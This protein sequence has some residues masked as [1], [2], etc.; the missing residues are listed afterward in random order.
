[1]KN[2]MKIPIAVSALLLTISS[3]S[4]GQAVPAGAPNTPISSIGSAPSAL[5]LD[6]TLHYALSAS[7]I[8]QYGYFGA[9]EVTH[10]TALSAD[11]AYTAKSMVYPFNVLFAGGVILQNQAGQGTTSFWNIEAS[12]GLV[13]RSWVFNV[14]DSFS[15]LPQSPT[16]G[17]SGI[18]G[19]GDLGSIPVQGPTEGP[20]GGIFSDAGNR[21][22][23]SVSGSAERQITRDTSISGS[24]SWLI[25]QFLGDSA[26]SG[27]NNSSVTGSVAVN[28]RLDARTSA[29][30]AAVYSTFTYSGVQSGFA[31]PDIETKGINLSFQRVLTRRLSVSVSA[32]PQWISSS[33]STLI[34]KSLNAAA[35]AGVSY[36]RG[37]TSASV[38]YSHGVNSGSGVLPGTE[39]DTFTGSLGRTFGRKWVASANLGYTRSA[40]L[41]QLANQIP[42]APIHAVYDSIFGGAQV[43]R[44]FGEHF[45]GFLSYTA[46]HQSSNSAFAGQNALNGTTQTFGIGVTYTPRSTRLGQF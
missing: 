24:G 7:E 45:S 22:S 2:M 21:I 29:S 6:G 14:S 19:V 40:G 18:P 43:T 1:M 23:N 34:P 3:I 30:L 17:L 27:L 8:I 9:G 37:L 10:S 11:A 44:A 16:T 41:T 13:T 15:F 4:H 42:A 35:S 33:N 25:F 26:N 46:Q 12:Q 31:T 36:S 32:G 38:S 5:A 20:A 39:S 28:R